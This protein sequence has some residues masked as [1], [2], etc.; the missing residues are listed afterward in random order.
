MDDKS[1]NP[2]RT[3]VGILSPAAET[4]EFLHGQLQAANFAFTQVEGDQY[5]MEK[6]DRT[7]RR[8]LEAQPQIILVDMQDPQAALQALRVLHEVL[9]KTWLFVTS[10]SDD[11]K[12]VIETMRAGAR[13]F[14]PKPV[15]VSILAQALE[16]YAAE[17][18]KAGENR[19]HGKIYCITAAKGGAGTTSVAVNLAVSLATARSA[20]VALLD[21]G[22][23]VGDAAEYLNLKSGFSVSDALAS[24]QRLDPV[25]L[26]T[27]MSHT[28]GVAVL[29]GLREF[30]PG[31]LRPD[32]LARML[33]VA[34]EAYTHTF[35][36][37][38]CSQNPEELEVV[39]DLS[40]A[41][42]IVMTPEL[43]ALWRTGRLIRLFEKTGG[44]EKLRLVLNRNSKRHELNSKEIEKTLGRPIYWRLPNNYPAAIG[45]VNSGKPLVAVNHSSLASAYFGL[46]QKLAGIPLRQ[47]RR[48]LFGMFS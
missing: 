17:R 11:S 7:A 38:S 37:I 29:P 35:I 30:R 14:L 43:P 6:A 46:A 33:G 48:G 21:L 13:E 41:V 31:L 34:A 23:P 9:P 8:F 18:Q 39:T 12:L 28:H 20:K 42:V 19:P 10:A 5:C 26:E 36:D 22:S 4:R 3:V 25:L 15:P 27:Y 24:A 16:R 2:E 45:A 47:T 1:V 40:T 32:A 44:G